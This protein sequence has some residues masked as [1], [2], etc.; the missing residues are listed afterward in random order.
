MIDSDDIKILIEKRRAFTIC[1]RGICVKC[2]PT[3]N[4]GWCISIPRAEVYIDVRDI[5]ILEDENFYD[6]TIDVNGSGEYY[7]L[8]DLTLYT[9]LT[10]GF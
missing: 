7:S 5:S 6:L 8:V 1:K 3:I 4:N 10:A 9:K 2:Y